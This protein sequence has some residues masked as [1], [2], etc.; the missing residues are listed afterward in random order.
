MTVSTTLTKSSHSANGTQHQF[1]YN[2]KIFVDGD[3]RVI[4][5]SATGTETVKVLNTDYIVT[6]AGS[7]S[8]NVLFKFNTGNSSDA[9]F[10]SSDKRPQNGETVVLARNLDLTQSTDYVANDPFPAEDHEKALD[11]LTFIVQ[12]LQEEL[13]RSI[14]VS[15]TNTI[16]S[17][18]F[19]VG[20][21]DRASKVLGFDSSGELSVTTEL[22][23]FRG[24]FAASTAYNIRDLI[25][26]TSTGNIFIVNTA[27]TSSGS[28]PLTTN[29]N[30]AKYTLLVDTSSAT[31]SAN[32]KSFDLF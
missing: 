11:R 18:E 10:S 20:A 6:N 17:S 5:R 29:A 30:S 9:H 2:F 25:K 3:L 26:D 32:V 22:G 1:A 24:N 16:T 21:T 14:K 12:E 7:N 27:H 8:G 13:N 15:E 4:I 31:A 23:T 19:T 28:Q